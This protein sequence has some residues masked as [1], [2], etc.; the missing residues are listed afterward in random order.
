MPI[1]FEKI[2]DKLKK[3]IAS[4]AKQTFAD[5]VKEAK[6]DG[7][8]LLDLLKTQLKRYT[9]Q[10]ASGELTNKEFKD[11]ILGQKAELE[12]AALKRAGITLVEADKF[13]ADVL[14]LISTTILG[15]V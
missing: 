10:L 14:N 3:D 15:L 13:K 2:F 1:N 8:H 4:L 12:M 11:L 7:Q 9:D 6:K 5:N